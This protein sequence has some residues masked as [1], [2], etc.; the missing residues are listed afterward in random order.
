MTAAAKKVAA[1]KKP[2]RGKNIAEAGLK[3]NQVLVLCALLQGKTREEA[4]ACGGVTVEGVKH[5]LGI[6]AFKRAY[7]AALAQVVQKAGIDAQGLIEALIPAATVDMRAFFRA[8]G[9]LLP[10]AEWTPE[11]GR[12]VAS[13]EVDELFDGVGEERTWVG[14]TRKLKFW[15]K[16]E[17]VDKLAKLLGAYQAKKHEHRVGFVVVPAKAPSPDGELQARPAITGQFVRQGPPR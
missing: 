9:T 2:A 17:A 14:Y 3:P 6:P 11:M 7:E 10:V 5:M 16:V 1:K 15:P 13:V 4:G 12:S 8:D